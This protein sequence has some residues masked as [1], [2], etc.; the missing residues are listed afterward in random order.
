MNVMLDA[1]IV[2]TSVH[3]RVAFIY[4]RLPLFKASEAKAS[5]PLRG[6]AE[7]SEGVSAAEG[8]EPS[9]G[10]SRAVA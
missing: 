1:R 9:R 6:Q 4:S 8:F 2:A 7:R 3:R 5:L 10:E